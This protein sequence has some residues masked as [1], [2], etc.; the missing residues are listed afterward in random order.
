MPGFTLQLG[1]V[2]IVSRLDS[3]ARD[4]LP[5][6]TDDKTIAPPVILHVRTKLRQLSLVILKVNR[7]NK[8]VFTDYKNPS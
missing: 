8:R 7:I 3:S 6:V 2:M 4:A 1:G 5:E